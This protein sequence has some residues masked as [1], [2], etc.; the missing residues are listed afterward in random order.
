MKKITWHLLPFY[1]TGQTWNH[2]NTIIQCIFFHL[3]KLLVFFF[4]L[5][6]TETNT[7]IEKSD[8]HL[9]KFFTCQLEHYI[10]ET[11]IPFTIWQKAFINGKMSIVYSLKSQIIE[12]HSMSSTVIFLLQRK[13]EMISWKKE[14][15]CKRFTPKC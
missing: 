5:R 14:R 4:L 1:F 15:S 7:L 6:M 11:I 8:L 10:K 12:K 9:L 13:T 2:F 3:L